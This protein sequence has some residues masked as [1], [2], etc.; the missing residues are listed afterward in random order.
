MYTLKR[1][2]NYEICTEDVKKT[3]DITVIDYGVRTFYYYKDVLSVVNE[4]YLTLLKMGINNELL[5]AITKIV[6]KLNNLQHFHTELNL[7]DEEAFT[8]NYLNKFDTFEY[9]KLSEF[10]K[11]TNIKVFKPRNVTNEEINSIERSYKAS[12]KERLNED[13]VDVRDNY[14]DYYVG[15]LEDDFYSLISCQKETRVI[16]IMDNSN[17]KTILKEMLDVFRAI[18]NISKDTISLDTY[19]F[20]EVTKIGFH[21]EIIYIINKLLLALN[22][23]FNSSSF[24]NNKYY[25]FDELEID[26]RANFD[27]DIALEHAKI[28]ATNQ[29]SH[30]FDK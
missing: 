19:Y 8:Q 29:L 16:S 30:K 27:L 10:D 11:S 26:N 3:D 15:D 5:N 1:N 20:F 22:Y 9:K 23:L 25:F 28:V 4:I 12:F 2:W 17:P 6:E 18:S 7:S 24:R 13:F 14:L 21:R